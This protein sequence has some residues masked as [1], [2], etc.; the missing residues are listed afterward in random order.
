M[1]GYWLNGVKY[2][3]VQLIA[4][5]NALSLDYWIGNANLTM[6]IVPEAVTSIEGTFQ[7]F[8]N[9]A[10]IVV[11]NSAQVVANLDTAFANTEAVGNDGLFWVADNLLT[12]YQTAYPTL[13]FDKWTNYT[14]YT[15]P[16]I[17][18]TEL[19]A[20]YVQ[21]L[22]QANPAAR[23]A[24]TVIVPVE[25]TS[26]ESGAITAIQTAFT[27]MGHLVTTYENGSID[28]DMNGDVVAKISAMNRTLDEALVYARTLTSLT[29]V[30]NDKLIIIPPMT[31]AY[32]ELNMPNIVLVS[33]LTFDSSVQSTYYLFNSLSNLVEV[34][35]T[36]KAK[37]IQWQGTLF[38]NEHASLKKVDMTF[39]QG[40]SES[41][42]APS[43][44]RAPSLESIVMN[45][46][47]YNLYLA[48]DTSLT[49]QAMA[50]LFNSLGT[51]ST[52]QSVEIGSTNLAK[53]TSA[54]IQIAYDKNWA[55]SPTPSAFTLVLNN[56]NY[57]C[58]FGMTWA[59]WIA[60]AYNTDGYYL[61]NGIVYESTGTNV[62]IESNGS[63]A[64]S[65]K[66]VRGGATY[67]VTSMPT[68][69]TLTIPF[70]SNITLTKAYVQSVID[71]VANKMEVGKVIV[72][73]GF[74]SF[75]NGSLNPISGLPN[76]ATLEFNYAFTEKFVDIYEPSATEK[77]QIAKVIDNRY[78]DIG[79]SVA[80]AGYYT[81]SLIEL[82][83]PNAT[84]FVPAAYG[85]KFGNN[86]GASNSA[87]IEKLNI[88]N[89]TAL[90]EFSI[91]FIDIK[92]I[93]LPEVLTVALDVFAGCYK[94]R[95]IELPK[96]TS[97]NGN[98]GSTP[99]LEKLF[100][101]TPNCTYGSR[102]LSFAD[103]NGK[104][105]V[106]ASALTTY[107]LSASGWSTYASRMVGFLDYTD[108]VPSFP[109]YTDTWYSN[110]DCTAIILPANF[111]SG[112]RYYVKLSF[113][114]QFTIPYNGNSTLTSAYVQALG[115]IS[116]ASNV[117]KV[118]IPA[119][120]TS[121][122][123][124]VIANVK[125]AF[126]NLTILEATYSGGS[127]AYTIS[128]SN[129]VTHADGWQLYEPATLTDIEYSRSLDGGDHLDTTLEGYDVS[130][131]VLYP[132][133]DF[134]QVQNARY[135][136][137]QMKNMLYVPPLDTRSV[138]NAELMFYMGQPN[139]LNMIPA[140]DLSNATNLNAAFG[141]ISGDTEP[142]HI[143]EFR[144]YGM[145]VSF[146]LGGYNWGGGGYRWNLTKDNIVSMFNGLQTVAS[147]TLTISKK[148]IDML[149]ADEKAIAT[150]KGWTFDIMNP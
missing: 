81:K 60:S 10:E 100:I 125:N 124:G 46:W 56:V 27:N 148:Y 30:D 128:S 61:D 17:G 105:Y 110:E 138:L 109:G 135:L 42:G 5:E 25:F 11:A 45:G 131:V 93:E 76:A 120:F 49:R 38:N 20:S 122:E 57:Q 80:N 62:V 103:A 87:T 41:T 35:A 132:F 14:Q 9:L 7:Q 101:G 15:I 19:T 69:S 150:D 89:V 64:M 48:Y 119:D 123:S 114:S 18:N 71:G 136:F 74:A 22:A 82:D 142:Q 34:K 65:N 26:Y 6:M 139:K 24:A 147:A 107:Y 37:I 77:G 43:I 92:E 97:F 13:N 63:I 143:I 4:G 16:F 73:T 88:P 118:I 12:A 52:S 44:I 96:V 85:Y 47:Q 68:L 98:Q 53:L 99:Y 55:I 126:S 23:A 29:S 70:V 40:T 66:L 116:G 90:G 2:S 79:T 31:T 137:N 8:P 51:P 75:E 140:F 32:K 121:Y 72:P 134:G 83:F 111:V 127:V 108:S 144:P 1:A 102:S 28:L 129:Q 104:I 21:Q 86:W 59:Q 94:V 84:S 106:P 50:D 145:K 130:K 149:S 117:T 36:F 146:R 133:L 58:D 115:G 78:G 91:R 33:D 3:N 113:S 141:Y 39:E 54:D 95:R 67:N 112:N